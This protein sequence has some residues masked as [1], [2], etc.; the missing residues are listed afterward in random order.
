V[1]EV[2]EDSLFMCESASESPNTAYIVDM[3]REA[4]RMYPDQTALIQGANSAPTRKISYRELMEQVDAAAQT[5]SVSGLKPYDRC[6][7]QG[8][9]SVEFIVQALAI[10][11][12]KSCLVPIAEDYNDA[13]LKALIFRCKLHGV[14]TCSE[15]TGASIEM[16]E[17]PEAVDGQDDREF[18]KI[19][20][21]F[22]RFTSGTTNERKGVVIGHHA[23]TERV[24]AANKG[25]EIGPEDR[26]LWMLPMAHHFLVSILLYLRNAATILLPEGDGVEELLDFAEQTEPTIIYASPDHYL[27]LLKSSQ[28]KETLS[29]AL[30]LALSTSMGLSQ[31]LA[32]EFYEIYGVY[33]TQA[34]GIIEVGLPVINVKNA[35]SKPLALGQVLPDYQ[36]I[37]KMNEEDETSRVGRDSGVGEVC[38]TGPGFFAAYLSPWI[39]A[40]EILIQEGFRTGD[41]GYF[42]EDRDLYLL[43]RRQNRINMG[44]RKFFCEEVESVINTFPGVVESRVRCERDAGDVV[45]AADVVIDSL[46]DFTDELLQAHCSSKLNG[47]KV[48][49]VIYPVA[50]LEKTPTGKIRRW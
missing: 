3:I 50:M 11:D 7:L 27:K 43:G 16:L 41:L 19:E 37:L 13:A 23:I 26:I 24:E 30:R 44:G 49:T 2:V 33:L 9:N 18:R 4:A 31:T 1:L 42:D 36:V 14:I 34:L 21:G 32:S 46:A 5:L 48:P 40:E 17:S 39:P 20:P 38:I 10:L 6:G 15:A 47:Y 35:G 22:I 29:P 25:L 12:L 28:R 8:G 45:V